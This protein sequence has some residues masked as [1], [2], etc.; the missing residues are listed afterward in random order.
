[1]SRFLLLL[2]GL[3]ALATAQNT[4]TTLDTPRL[5]GSE[6]MAPCC[7]LHTEIPRKCDDPEARQKCRSLEIT[8]AICPGEESASCCARKELSMDLYFKFEVT[9]KTCCS[10]CRCYGDPHCESFEGKADTWVICDARN[11]KP[12]NIAQCPMNKAV[13][14][15]QV[16]HTGQPCHWT[17]TP[18]QKD[19]S[20]ALMGSPCRER[21]IIQDL[22]I[23]DGKKQYVL[24]AQE[25]F[26]YA[27]NRT[28]KTAWKTD[29]VRCTRTPERVAGKIKYGPPRLNVE[30][31]EPMDWHDIDRRPNIGGFC[32]DGFIT[33]QG[34]TGNT[35]R[36]TA[37]NACNSET[38]NLLVAQALCGRGCSVALN[39]FGART[40]TSNCTISGGQVQG[41]LELPHVH[42][43]DYGR[44][45]ASGYYQEIGFKAHIE[46]TVS[47]SKMQ[48]VNE[49]FD[50]GDLICNPQKFPS[51][52]SCFGDYVPEKTLPLPHLKNAVRIT[53][54]G[55]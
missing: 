6:S 50:R 10:A 28:E 38:D 46:V 30:I 1:M 23:Q 16:D 12:G 18:A 8:P 31:V 33:K 37:M 55:F 32:P 20:I 9:N 13:C 2:A 51:P 24:G 40:C 47:E 15:N 52:D 36:I 44:W 39:V 21:S 48:I 19:W 5:C 34:S 11:P 22:I 14:E 43:Y 35:D 17:S 3:A 26:N 7:R 42:E 45:M 29:Y 4:C 25:C 27:Y 41:G 49:L 53:G 54:A